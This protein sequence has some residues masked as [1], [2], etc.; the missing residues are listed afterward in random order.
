MLLLYFPQLFSVQIYNRALTLIPPNLISINIILL[1]YVSFA[2]DSTY[3]IACNV[4]SSQV[5]FQCSQGAMILRRTVLG[6]AHIW[7]SIVGFSSVTKE[8]PWDI[9]AGDILRH[10]PRHWYPSYLDAGL[11]SIITSSSRI[12]RLMPSSR[13]RVS[14]PSKYSA[15]HLF[16]TVLFDNRGSR[17]KHLSDRHVVIQTQICIFFVSFVLPCCFCS[18]F[19]GKSL[20]GLAF[21]LHCSPSGCH[22]YCLKS[23][24]TCNPKG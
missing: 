6:T 17:L 23:S 7:L 8:P 2:Q 15:L 19:C 5:R 21:Q 22:R 11:V 10:H 18:N 24:S 20:Q 1:L 12:H 13:N 14:P 16:H 9:A 3:V 4:I